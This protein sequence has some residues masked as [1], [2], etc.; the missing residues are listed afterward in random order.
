MEEG[1]FRLLIVSDDSG[2]REDVYFIE[3]ETD[4]DCAAE[5]YLEPGQSVIVDEVIEAELPHLFPFG[6]QLRKQV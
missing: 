1:K 2:M 4:D 5:D 6:R 3:P